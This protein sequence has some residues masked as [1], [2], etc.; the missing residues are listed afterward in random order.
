MTSL[1][2]PHLSQTYHYAIIR[3]AYASDSHI[4]QA[5]AL[6]K[7]DYWLLMTLRTIAAPKGP[8]PLDPR[9]GTMRHP[10]HTDGVIITNRGK[11]NNPHAMYNKKLV[12]LNHVVLKR[13]RQGLPDREDLCE[14]L[15]GSSGHTRPGAVDCWVYPII[16]ETIIK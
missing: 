13:K 10:E 2:H 12:C 1:T 6:M 11:L 3:C 5:K 15:R 8:N 4:L 14:S 9:V 7:A 16:Y